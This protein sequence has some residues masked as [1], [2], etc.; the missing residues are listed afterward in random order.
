LVGCYELWFT[1]VI[2]FS[3]FNVAKNSVETTCFRY[4][5]ASFRGWE[6]PVAPGA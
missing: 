5:A 6:T 1:C 3:Y 4:F 2:H